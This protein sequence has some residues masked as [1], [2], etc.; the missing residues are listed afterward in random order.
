MSAEISQRE[1]R[2]DSGRIMRAVIEGETFIV[3]RNGEPIGELSPLR[4]HRFV[5]AEAAIELFRT[6]PAIDFE[7]LRRDLDGIAGQT[8][9]PRA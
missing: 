3:T 4:R 8:I 9:T 6:A 2:N 7:R 5:R 1:L